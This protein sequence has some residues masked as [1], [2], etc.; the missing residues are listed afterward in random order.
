MNAKKH[1]DYGVWQC[2]G[3]SA[4]I[5][6]LLSVFLPKLVAAFQEKG[7]RWSGVIQSW[8]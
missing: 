5:R 8:H 3:I 2:D 7:L 4:I 1:V 6:P